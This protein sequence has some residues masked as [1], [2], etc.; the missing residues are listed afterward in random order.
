MRFADKFVDALRKNL[1]NRSWE[2]SGQELFKRTI[3][4]VSGVPFDV[5]E[6]NAIKAQKEMIEKYR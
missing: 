3:E 2:I 6:K 5:Y 4:E 1:S